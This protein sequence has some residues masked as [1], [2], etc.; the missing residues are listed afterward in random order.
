MV[1]DYG[2]IKPSVTIKEAL[3]SQIT[4][5]EPKD[6]K[7]VQL[8]NNIL[9]EEGQQ[10]GQP[11]Q[12]CVRSVTS[13]ERIR[14]DSFSWDWLDTEKQTEFHKIHSIK[15][16]LSCYNISTMFLTKHLN[17]LQVYI[18]FFPNAISS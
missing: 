10:A 8:V 5:T 1:S 18:N 6:G 2:K 16:F 17:L 15:T 4:D 11:V 13:Q 12:F 3:G 14:F 7:F 9:W